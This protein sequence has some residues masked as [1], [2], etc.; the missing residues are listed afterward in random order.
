VALAQIGDT[1]SADKEMR[2]GHG[3]A[4]ADLD[5]ALITVAAHYRLAAAQLNMAEK[6]DSHALQSALFP[7]PAYT[8]GNGFAVDPALIYAFMRQESGFKPQAKSYAGARGLMQIMPATAVHIA[9]DRSLRYHNRAKLFDPAYNLR[10]AQDYI[11]ELL[12]NVQPKGNLF[13]LT[14]AYNGG[15]GNLQ[16]WLSEMEDTNDPLLF[17]ESVPARETRVYVERVL[18]NL[19][20]YRY[21]LGEDVPSLDEVAEGGWPVYSHEAPG[22]RASAD[23]DDG[24]TNVA[25]VPQQ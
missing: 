16:R 4:S 11:Q 10:L 13:A 23:D 1:E 17:I 15:P 18:T 14:V 3:A 25:S 2:R 5:P 8:P 21:R 22:S 12:G 9:G 19:W 6:S 7:I 24:D 20:I